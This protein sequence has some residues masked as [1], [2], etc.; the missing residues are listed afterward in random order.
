MRVLAVLTLVVC[1]V[2]LIITGAIAQR[3]GGPPGGGGP[4]GGGPGGGGGPRFIMGNVAAVNV[5][6][7][8]IDITPQGQQDQVISVTVPDDA[9]V[10]G[11][12]DAKV[13]DLN[14]GDT[15]ELTGF[16]AQMIAQSVR[17]G[18][19]VQ[20]VIRAAFADP[21]NPQAQQPVNRGTTFTGTVTKV[22]PLTLDLGDGVTVVVAVGA[23]AETTKIGL[24]E[25]Q[26]IKPTDQI[27][28]IGPRD[29]QGRVTA[30]GI[31][32]DR[33]KNGEALRQ[34]FGF[35]G[36]PPG[37]FGGGFGGF[38]GRGPQGGPPGGDQGRN[39]QGGGADEHRTTQ[40]AEHRHGQ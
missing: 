1:V 40:G 21:N 31:A 11:I 20:T 26:Q 6:T 13:T 28:A 35:G 15:V 36:G 10:T 22:D 5:G 23:N 3:P 39:R 27:L 17:I 32:V 9:L 19:G 37:M 38:G 33:T 16:P 29:A 14:V 4:G 30:R 2:A 18:G 12:V 7:R 8:T 25:L 34:R 24:L